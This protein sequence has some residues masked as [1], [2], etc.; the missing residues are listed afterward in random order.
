MRRWAL[1]ALALAGCSHPANLL[2][3]SPVLDQLQ[4]VDGRKVAPGNVEL[5]VEP[6]DAEVEVD[7]VDVGRASDFDGQQGCLQLREGSHH[8]VVSKAGF[9][10]ADMTL[11]ASDE[12]RQRVNLELTRSP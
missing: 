2:P 7:G 12:G 8:V 1:G 9:Q 11:F 5:H 4:P 6:G 10:S 3:P